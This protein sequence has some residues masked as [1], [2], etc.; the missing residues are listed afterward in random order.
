M[1]PFGTLKP[2]QAFQL[3]TDGPIFKKWPGGYMPIAG[4]EVKT[5][6]PRDLVIVYIPKGRRE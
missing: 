2:G 4:G 5:L 6:G 3:Q 1:T